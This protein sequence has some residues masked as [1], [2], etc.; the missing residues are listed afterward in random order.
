M[1]E[2]LPVCFL[3]AINIKYCRNITDTQDGQKLPVAI[4]N[5]EFLNSCN[6][7]V[8]LKSLHVLFLLISQQ[9]EI[10]LIDCIS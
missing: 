5:I 6:A 7:Q 4:L 9:L 10:V 3:C 8:K 2:K 1:N